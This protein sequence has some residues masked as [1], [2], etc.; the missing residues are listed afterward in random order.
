MYERSNCFHQLCER[1]A[2]LF[3]HSPDDFPHT[4]IGVLVTRNSRMQLYQIDITVLFYF[5]IQVIR[6]IN[7]GF[8]AMIKDIGVGP[9]LYPSAAVTLVHGE[10]SSGTNSGMLVTSPVAMLYEN[11]VPGLNS[12]S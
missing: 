9:G 8:A 1:E 10:L 3:H 11:L 6:F 7:V 12:G 4:L 5:G 2:G